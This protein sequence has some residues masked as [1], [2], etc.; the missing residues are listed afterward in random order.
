M[1]ILRIL[2]NLLLFDLWL[3][4]FLFQIIIF[5]CDRF[6]WKVLRFDKKTR[7]V[8]MGACKRS[9]ICCQTLGIEVPEAWIRRPWAL[10]LVRAWYARI[11]NFQTA[12]PPQGRLLPM[13]CGYLRGLSDCSI[14]PYRP[15]LCREF[16]QVSLFG[17]IELHRGCGFWF[18]ER[19]KLGGFGQNLAEKEHENAA[20]LSSP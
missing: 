12:G 1:A 8:R 4:V 16:P 15:K 7:Y 6:A 10:S 11:H 3:G 18:L 20:N 9:G 13:S 19:S 2:K 14:Y 5:C 17:Y